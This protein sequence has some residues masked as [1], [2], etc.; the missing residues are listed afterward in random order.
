MA[1]HLAVFVAGQ[2]AS[3]RILLGVEIVNWRH[4]RGRERAGTCRTQKKGSLG[5]VLTPPFL[6]S[7]RLTPLVLI[8]F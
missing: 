2:P 1:G 7:S 6:C 8:C 4:R 3:V 5:S